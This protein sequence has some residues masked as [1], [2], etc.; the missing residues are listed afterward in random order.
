MRVDA[1][2]GRRGRD[3]GGGLASVLTDT[4]ARFLEAFFA[5][6][7]ADSDAFYLSGGTDQHTVAT[8]PILE[9]QSSAASARTSPNVERRISASLSPDCS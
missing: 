7:K 9:G 2:C 1:N 3:T 6:E 5:G 8:Q 4:Q